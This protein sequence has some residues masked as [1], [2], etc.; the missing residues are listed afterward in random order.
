MFVDWENERLFKKSNETAYFV[1]PKYKH[2]KAPHKWK[3]MKELND[4]CGIEFKNLFCGS[5]EEIT[6]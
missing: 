3:T 1:I 2:R 5:C 6:F 4:F